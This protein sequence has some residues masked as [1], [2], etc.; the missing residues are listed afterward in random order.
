MRVI[1]QVNIVLINHYATLPAMAGGTRHFWFARELVQRGHQVAIVASSFNHSARRETRR[2][3]GEKHQTETVDGVRLVWLKTP[4]YTGNT[5]ARVRNMLAFTHGLLRL[6]TDAFGFTPDIVYGSSPHLFAAWAAHRLAMR[7]R[8]PFVLEVRDLWPESLIELGSFSRRHPFI[9]LLASIERYLYSNADHIISLLPAAADF[10]K[11]RGAE[12]DRISWIPNGI[13]LA[14]VP[15]PP[16]PPNNDSF[17]VMYAG[18]HGLANNLDLVLDAAAALRLSGN[19]KSI[20]FRL[21]GDGP[22]K[23]RLMKRAQEM[24]L[25]NVVFDEPVPKDAVFDTLAQAD[26]FL[27]TLHDSSLFRWGISPNKLF[28]YMAAARP[29]ILTLTAPYCPGDV[30]P[31]G[32]FSIPNDPEQLVDLILQLS[33][34]P[35]EQRQKLGTDAR[36][37]VE[38]HHAM[39]LLVDRLEAVL[40]HTMKSTVNRLS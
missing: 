38:Q 34:M 35:S 5:L 33:K 19:T 27:L 25:T 30:P 18:T 32:I 17:D 31:S 15:K 12:A 40:Q 24:G 14:M 4:P 26:C 39:N 11:S 10:I 37:Y 1:Y 29:I 16:E 21:V 6:P 20:R 36:R 28:D 7:R 9:V 8:I 23:L 22:D 2:W 13:D 3:R